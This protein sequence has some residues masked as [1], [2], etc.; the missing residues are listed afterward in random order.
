[1]FRHHKRQL[2][3]RRKMKKTNFNK[4][5]NTPIR[6][7]LHNYTFNGTDKAIQ[8][9]LRKEDIK[10]HKLDLYSMHSHADELDP[11]KVIGNTRQG[12]VIERYKEI[13]REL[14]NDIESSVVHDMTKWKNNK[15]KTKAR[16]RDRRLKMNNSAFNNVD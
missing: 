2:K 4:E 9:R 7:P 10:V 5:K 15:K 12:T 13:K 1:M 8:M 6:D 14:E 3:E 11:D 16:N